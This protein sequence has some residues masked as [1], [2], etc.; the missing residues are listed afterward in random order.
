MYL[1]FSYFTNLEDIDWA[2]LESLT[3]D[4][5]IETDGFDAIKLAATF[6]FSPTANRMIVVLTTKEQVCHS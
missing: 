1:Y 4:G 3:A 5:K 2:S 6:P